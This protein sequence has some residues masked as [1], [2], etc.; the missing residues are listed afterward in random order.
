MSDM[1]LADAANVIR[2]GSKFWRM[3]AKADEAI[4]VI[5]AQMGLLAQ[6]ETEIRAIDEKLAAKAAELATASASVDAA[7]ARAAQILSKASEDAKAVADQSKNDAEAVAEA[8]AEAR[9]QLKE[10][11]DAR[12]VAMKD[13]DAF[14][15]ELERTKEQIKD[16][17]AKA[18]ALLA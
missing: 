4:D 10:A 9:Q 1:S 8:V 17:K 14:R 16:A 15:A 18:L 5:E 11:Q 12:A 3:W 6:R 7:N 13:A 2:S